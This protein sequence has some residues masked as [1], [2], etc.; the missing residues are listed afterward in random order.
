M[1]AITVFYYDRNVRHAQLF[2]NEQQ[3]FVRQRG[4]DSWRKIITASFMADLQDLNWKDYTPHVAI[5]DAYD[6]DVFDR[7]VI[8]I[9]DFVKRNSREIDPPYH[10]IRIFLLRTEADLVGTVAEAQ[11]TGIFGEAIYKN[12]SQ[13]SVPERLGQILHSKEFPWL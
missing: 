5:F 1:G 9:A 8:T 13:Y 7:D 12:S 4:A 6:G 2:S 10:Q 3:E 11:R